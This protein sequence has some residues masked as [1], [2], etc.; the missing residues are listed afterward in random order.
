MIGLASSESSLKPLPL[1]VAL[2]ELFGGRELVH[3]LRCLGHST[4]GVVFDELVA[5]RGK[6]EGDV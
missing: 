4:K 3:L 5:V 1:F 6:G 2:A